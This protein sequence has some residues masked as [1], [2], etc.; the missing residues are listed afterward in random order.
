MGKP[1]PRKNQET[2]GQPWPRGA[3]LSSFPDYSV[4]SSYDQPLRYQE[5]HQPDTALH[6]VAKGQPHQDQ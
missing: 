6:E 1:A 3:I 4:H 2:E 5:T